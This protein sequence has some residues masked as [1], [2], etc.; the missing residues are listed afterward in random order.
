MEKFL[1]FFTSWKLDQIFGEQLVINHFQYFEK[2]GI[3]WDV[4]VA[5]ESEQRIELMKKN[6]VKIFGE[7][8]DSLIEAQHNIFSRD[9]GVGCAE[10]YLCQINAKVNQVGIKTELQKYASRVLSLFF[11]RAWGLCAKMDTLKLYRAIFEGTEEQ[12]CFK[13]Y[14]KKFCQV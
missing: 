4:L 5:M 1:H 14:V 10:Y 9:L 11:A 2:R 12:I 13:K 3:S 8:L 6:L 7:P